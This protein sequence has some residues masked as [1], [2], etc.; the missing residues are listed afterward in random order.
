MEMIRDELL[1]QVTGG[2]NGYVDECSAYRN[3]CEIVDGEAVFPSC[4]YPE[5]KGKIS[6]CN[7]CISSREN[8]R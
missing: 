6:Y 2:A 5:K 4:P 8:S 3:T 7:D 1:S